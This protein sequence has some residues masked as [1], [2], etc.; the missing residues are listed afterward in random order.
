MLMTCTGRMQNHKCQLPQAMGDP[1][2]DGKACATP[3]KVLVKARAVACGAGA[4]HT[5]A[6]LL[7]SKL[8]NGNVGRHLRVHAGTCAIGIFEDTRALSHLLAAV[9]LAM[10]VLLAMSCVRARTLMRMR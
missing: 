1:D 8:A 10:Q 7:R 3:M 5:P 4:L 6:L 2:T 9:H